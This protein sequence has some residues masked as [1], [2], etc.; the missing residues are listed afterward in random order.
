MYGL[1]AEPLM[2]KGTN[3]DGK[4]QVYGVVGVAIGLSPLQVPVLHCGRWR[5]LGQSEVDYTIANSKRDG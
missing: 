1:E 3:N 5:V 4:P 2:L